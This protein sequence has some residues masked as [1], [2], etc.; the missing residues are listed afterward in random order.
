MSEVA[1]TGACTKDHA[2]GAGLDA[3]PAGRVQHFFQW[4]FGLVWLCLQEVVG[5]S[6]GYQPERWWHFPPWRHSKSHL[7]E[8][9]GNGSGGPA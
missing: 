9:L 3:V 1:G 4:L 7:Y 8:A 2:A 6:G 5:D